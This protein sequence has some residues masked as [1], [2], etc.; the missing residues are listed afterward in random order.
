MGSLWIQNKL[1][2]QGVAAALAAELDRESLGKLMEAVTG[3]GAQLFVTALGR[4]DVPMDRSHSLFHVEQGKV[5]SV[6]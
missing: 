5:V 2:Q 4:H 3:L 6:V 1:R